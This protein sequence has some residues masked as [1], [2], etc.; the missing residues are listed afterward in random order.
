MDLVHVDYLGDPVRQGLG[1]FLAAHVGH[2]GGSHLRK[3]RQIIALGIG[4]IIIVQGRQE[5]L[6][7]LIRQLRQFHFRC[8]IIDKRVDPGLHRFR[9][10]IGLQILAGLGRIGD[11]LLA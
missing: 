10:Q 2:E 3:V 4:L 7:V 8:H 9:G 1:S 11:L 6:Q 5:M